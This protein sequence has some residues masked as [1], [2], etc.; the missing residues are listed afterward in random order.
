LSG[1]VARGWDPAFRNQVLLDVDA[2]GLLEVGGIFF[3]SVLYGHAP[4]CHSLRLNK[5]WKT[6]STQ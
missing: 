2:S 3:E 6:L 4:A 5:S 1:A